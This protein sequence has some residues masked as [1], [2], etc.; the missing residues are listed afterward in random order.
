MNMIEVKF[1]ADLRNF[2]AG[3]VAKI[4]IGKDGVTWLVGKN[5]CGKS[6]ILQLLR[7]RKD[8][9][10]QINKDCHDGMTVASLDHLKDA[11]VEIK[12]LDDYKHCFYFDAVIDNPVSF[13]NAATAGGLIGGG[14]LAYTKIS[15]GQGANFLLVSFIKKIKAVLEKD[16]DD[17]DAKHLIVLD[18]IDEGLDYA[19]Q[20]ALAKLL[21]MLHVLHNADVICVSHSI[22][23]IMSAFDPTVYMFGDEKFMPVA[24]YISQMIGK[25]ITIADNAW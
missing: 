15:R 22:L 8:S 13:E 17:D 14:G 4:E 16:A 6:T 20:V 11:D 18:E 1:N 12:G 24:E 25:T 7:S 5:G 2:K 21:T 19:G 23:P 10:Y 3:D 9:L